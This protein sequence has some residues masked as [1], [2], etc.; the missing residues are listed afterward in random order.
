MHQLGKLSVL[1]TLMKSRR[2]LD[3][4]WPWAGKISKGGYGVYVVG[5]SS[6]CGAH[7]ASYAAFVGAIPIGLAID[8][9]CRNR[10]CVNP[11]HLEAVTIAENS[12]RG[13]TK[14]HCHRGHLLSGENLVIYG[15]HWRNCRE[16][17][18][19]V[20]SR[21]RHVWKARYLRIRVLKGRQPKACK[22]CGK[23]WME[24]AGGGKN[25]F[26]GPRCK[27]NWHKKHGKRGR[28]L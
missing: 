10:A 26:C 6:N 12:R 8:H 14:T 23:D 15:G 21:Y 24:R 11:R 20:Y 28:L 4:C 16:C 25:L 1:N 7:R 22:E 27:S 2:G 19:G 9:L 5:S 13:S 18:K 17:R 3:E